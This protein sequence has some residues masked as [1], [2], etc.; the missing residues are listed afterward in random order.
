LLVVVAG[1]ALLLLTRGGGGGG[2][3]AATSVAVE[4]TATPEAF[5]NI[6]AASQN[7]AR[8]SV[9][10]EDAITLIPWPITRLLPSAI[11][12]TAQVIGKRARY[13]IP[14]GD[15]VLSTMVV[16]SL[17]DIS[18]FGSDAA[19]RIPPGMV[20]ITLP[21]D[22]HSG[23]ALG[24][25]DGDHVNVIVSWM[26]VDIDQDFQTILPNLTAN[27]VPP[28]PGDPANGVPAGVVNTV[29]AAGEAQGRGV[30]D[31]ALG[32]DFY[33]IPFEA[34]RPRLVTQGVIQDA[35]VLHMG[36]FAENSPTFVEPTPTPGAAPVAGT[37]GT[38][39]GPP[40]PTSTPLPPDSITLIVSNQ[41]ALVLEYVKQVAAKNAGSVQVTFALRSAGDSSLTETESVT[42]QYMFERFAIALPSK[43]AY[44]VAAGA[45]TATPAP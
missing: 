29:S 12:D 21:Y 32:R 20:A 17:L 10:P 42:L 45:P 31:A 13:D 30:T 4:V 2:G 22:K 3:G 18:P 9:I 19:A 7:L 41:D 33:V 37:E 25:N 39:T 14:R 23:V 11:T 28:S 1:A 26:L 8:G 16:D 44:G 34:Q 6:V 5:V 43:L 35:V 36:D 24:I 40:P 38:P 15:P 27:V